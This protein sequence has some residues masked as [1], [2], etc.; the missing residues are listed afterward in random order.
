MLTLGYDYNIWKE[1]EIKKKI[2]VNLRSISSI[3]L[4]GSS[5]SG[6]SYALKWLMRNLL[7]S[8]DVEITFCNFKNSDD[9]KFL[10]GYRKYYTYLNC[11][12]GLENYYNEFKQAQNQEAEYNGKYYKLIFDEF[13]AFILS[14]EL[15]DKKMAGRSRSMINELL[16]LSRS[17]G[18]GVICI[19]QRP[20]SSFLGGT[21]GRDNYQANIFLGNTS[22]ESRKMLYSGLDLP[23]DCNGNFKIYSPGSGLCFVDGSGLYEIMIPKIL[24]MKGLER[25]I[26]DRLI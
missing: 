26:L 12:E 16:M 11:Q 22:V 10:N 8:Y 6:K 19:M 21:Y 1:Y 14:S 24:D 25:E 18:Y 15:L 7:V 13:P 20:D 9:F 3:L 5:G 17:Y 2:E 23:K 4:C